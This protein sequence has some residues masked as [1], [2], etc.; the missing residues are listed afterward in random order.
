VGRHIYVD[1]E[2]SF[3]DDFNIPETET[4]KAEIPDSLGWLRNLDRKRCSFTIPYERKL[5]EYKPVF[6]DF[7]FFRQ[8]G[9][10]VVVDILDPHGAHLDDAV[11]YNRML[12]MS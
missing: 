10:R 12:W 4:L 1:D 7:L 5:G 8:E 9:S 6:P 3:F 11:S 2:A